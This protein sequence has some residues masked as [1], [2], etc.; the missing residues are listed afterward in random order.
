MAD[1]YFA[2]GLADSDI[3]PQICGAPPSAPRRD[4]V[5]PPGTIPQLILAPPDANLV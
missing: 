5:A 3:N 2:D 1:K 4:D